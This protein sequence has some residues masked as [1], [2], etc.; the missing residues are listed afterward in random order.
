MAKILVYNNNANRMETYY[1]GLSEAMPYNSNRTLTV[2]EFQGS[3]NSNIMW[4]DLRTMESWNSLR[5]LYGRPIYVGFAFKRC[6]Q[7]GHSNLS[8]HYAGTAFDAAQTATEEQRAIIRNLARQVWNY[9]EPESLTPRWVHFDDR[10]VASGYP[11]TRNGSRGIY[12]CVAQDAL[13]TLGY[14]TGGLDGVFGSR[15]LESVRSYQRQKGLSVDGIIG[16]NTWRSLMADVVGKGPT[17]TT[18]R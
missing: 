15:T 13:T 10:W 9:V 3:S 18:V 6:W 14:N 5:Y 16:P 7:G 17:D 8:Q 12:V 11:N 2:R 1:K 4:T